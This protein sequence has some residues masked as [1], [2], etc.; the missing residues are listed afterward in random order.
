MLI[1]VDNSQKRKNKSTMT[2][3]MTYAESIQ[4][5]SPPINPI[6]YSTNTYSARLIVTQFTTAR[7]WIQHECHI[8]DKWV[9]K[10]L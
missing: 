6:S 9:I 8:N 5:P 10:I 4:Y 1:S 2:H 7:K 3:S